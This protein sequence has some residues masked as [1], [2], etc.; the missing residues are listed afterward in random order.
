MLEIAG[1]LHPAATVVQRG[2]R[3][4]CRCFRSVLRHGCLWREGQK[5]GNGKN[6]EEIVCPL[7]AISQNHQSDAFRFV[8]VWFPV[9]LRAELFKAP[10]L[11]SG[12]TDRVWRAL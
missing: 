2:H 8:A 3:I 5:D 7:Q 1:H 4:R 10:W 9:Q 6:R 11:V 12:R